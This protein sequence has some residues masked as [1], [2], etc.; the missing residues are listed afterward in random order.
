MVRKRGE[1]DK[2]EFTV[3][4]VDAYDGINTY[5]SGLSETPIKRIEDIVSF[6]SQNAGTEGAA[7]GDVPA[8]RSGQVLIRGDLD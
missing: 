1:P 3:V 6:N 2:S 8:F 5:L 4:K 7:P